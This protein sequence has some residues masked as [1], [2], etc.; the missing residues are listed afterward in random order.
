M[1]FL[2]F[3]LYIRSTDHLPRSY[4]RSPVKVQ[5]KCLEERASDLTTLAE[6]QENVIDICAFVVVLQ[7]IV[8]I[9][10]Q[11]CKDDSM[12]SIGN[13]IINWWLTWCFVVN[14]W[15]ESRSQLVGVLQ[16]LAHLLDVL[17][18]LL[19]NAGLAEGSL[20]TGLW[21]M[22]AHGQ[23]HNGEAREDDNLCVNHAAGEGGKREREKNDIMN[24]KFGPGPGAWI[25]HPH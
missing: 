6:A 23:Q 13:L 10:N 8:G 24:S 15:L 5:K 19:E 21:A 1:L 7:Q 3:V 11:C 22:H 18:H 9:G 25:T 16:S 12:I 4:H 14:V 17:R 20:C 2:F